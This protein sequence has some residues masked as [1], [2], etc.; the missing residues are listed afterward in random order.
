V[1][2]LASIP[3]A[4]T[5]GYTLAHAHV[6]RRPEAL[7]SWLSAVAWALLV[8]HSHSTDWAALCTSTA[9]GGWPRIDELIGAGWR[10]GAAPAAMAHWALMSVAMVPLLALP[11]LRFVA[12]RSFVER[13]FRAVAEFL[14]G[15]LAVW[16]LVGAA[17]LPV[18]LFSTSLAASHASAVPIAL[19]LAALWQL[20]PA[21]RR[22]LQ[23]CHR[24]TAL[25]ARGWH[26]DRDCVLFGMAYATSCVISC[27]ALMLACAV[28][29]HS[30]AA[31]LL[32]QG[33]ALHERA[34]QAPLLSRYSLLLAGCAAAA[35]IGL[36][37][38]P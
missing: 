23:R 26:A 18:L 30:L 10:S 9:G 29:P 14:V 32:V 38:L 31:L 13:R 4:V 15:S 5:H 16:M 8:A 2:V 19:S 36:G 34:S 24:T 21:K 33:I 27:W 25:A 11:M 3:Y 7:L 17:L 22:A 20:T 28:A 6:A 12:A 35:A 1:R 37:V